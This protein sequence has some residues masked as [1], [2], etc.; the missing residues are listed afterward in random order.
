MQSSVKLPYLIINIEFWMVANFV[1]ISVRYLCWSLNQSSGVI[2]NHGRA[3]HWVLNLWF[4]VLYVE[5]YLSCL[6]NKSFFNNV[7]F[8]PRFYAP[9]KFGAAMAIVKSDIGGNITVSNFFQQGFYWT[10]IIQRLSSF[11]L[12][13]AVVLMLYLS[14]LYVVIIHNIISIATL[15]W[16]TFC[17]VRLSL[18]AP[19]QFQVVFSF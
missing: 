16:S 13:W 18:L 10:S 12:C 4:Y 9:D 17:L 3:N 19:L 8:V 2:L 11:L 7:P 1:H 15:D 6:N 5:L 14:Y